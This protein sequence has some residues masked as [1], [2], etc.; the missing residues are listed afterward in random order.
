MD[1]VRLP[2]HWVGDQ[3]GKNI[4]DTL[5]KRSTI[6]NISQYQ[7]TAHTSVPLPYAV[8]TL[9][10]AP[11]LL[12]SWFHRFRLPLPP[13]PPPPAPPRLK[14]VSHMTLIS[15]S[16]NRYINLILNKPIHPFSTCVCVCAYEWNNWVACVLTLNVFIYVWS[17]S[18]KM[19]QLSAF[20]LNL[21]TT[22]DFGC[23]GLK[24][25]TYRFLDIVLQAE[26][27]EKGFRF[28]KFNQQLHVNM[29]WFVKK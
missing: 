19:H 18:C 14:Q 29:P 4:Q 26:I 25:V 15:A 6:C 1:N 23:Q 28:C 13:L 5:N 7:I 20:P 27:G 8:L 2:T 16:D 17:M 12:L 10:L 21:Q 11:R 9:L 3:R 22:D 24:R